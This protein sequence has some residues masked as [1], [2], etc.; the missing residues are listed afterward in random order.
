M[1]LIGILGFSGTRFFYAQIQCLTQVYSKQSD[2]NGSTQMQNG[3][4]K[5]L[6]FELDPNGD[7]QGKYKLRKGLQ[8]HLYISQLP[9]QF[10]FISKKRESFFL[11]FLPSLDLYIFIRTNQ[12]CDYTYSPFLQVG[13]HLRVHCCLPQ[14]TSHQ[15]NGVHLWTSLMF[16]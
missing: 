12:Y 3:D 16:Q 8:L 13:L 9:C 11:R 4:A 15:Q 7:G 1:V 5:N 2:S 6:L 10:L 14:K